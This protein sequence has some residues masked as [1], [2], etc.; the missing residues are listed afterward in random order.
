MP[1][2]FE[3]LGGLSF[4]LAAGFLAAG[5]LAAGFFAAGFSVLTG[6]SSGIPLGISVRP[7]RAILSNSF[8]ESMKKFFTT[9]SQPP[10]GVLLVVSALGLIRLN[11]GYP[12]RCLIVALLTFW[13]PEAFFITAWSCVMLYPSSAR[14]CKLSSNVTHTAS[15]NLTCSSDAVARRPPVFVSRIALYCLIPKSRVSR[16]A[17]RV[18]LMVGTCSDSGMAACPGNPWST[19]PTST[20]SGFG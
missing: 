11:M 19:V 8:A 5:F 18:G 13:L 3:T 16:K 4:F 14:A 1:L 7:S 17:L 6:A 9:C 2:V 15:A 12:P 10:T 20:G